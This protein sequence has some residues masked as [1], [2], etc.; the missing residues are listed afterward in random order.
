M[1]A[2]GPDPRGYAPELAAVKDHARTPNRTRTPIRP[3]V[4]LASRAPA[5]AVPASR[6]PCVLRAPP[7]G[8]RASAVAPPRPSCAP[9]PAPPPAARG[10]GS[11]G[12]MGPEDAIT[13]GRQVYAR[14]WGYQSLSSRLSSPSPGV[15]PRSR[16]SCCSRAAAGGGTGSAPAPLGRK[17][18]ARRWREITPP[19]AGRR[20]EAAQRRPGTRWRD[21]RGANREL[22]QLKAAQAAAKAWAL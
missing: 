1:A 3:P 13:P 17:G 6:C 14:A 12:E 18:R 15:P 4:L 7:P 21:R 19:P 8:L 11:G 22:G 9:P 20:L 16:P 5:A 10:R 2:A